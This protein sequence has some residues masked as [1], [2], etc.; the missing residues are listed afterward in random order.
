M[1]FYIKPRLFLQVP[2]KFPLFDSFLSY[3]YSQQSISEKKSDKFNRTWNYLVMLNL[4]F[5]RTF[6][7]RQKLIHE[8]N[9]L[10]VLNQFVINILIENSSI[11]KKCFLTTFSNESS[12]LKCCNW[13]STEA[14]IKRQKWFEKRS[15]FFKMTRVNLYWIKFIVR[16]EQLCKIESKIK[17]WFLLFS[18]RKVVTENLQKRC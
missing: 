10:A 15:F 9:C 5:R 12:D 18:L 1:Y 13:K 4:Y 2:P 3:S 16:N 8:N 14:I 7:C 6:V 17:L 11:S